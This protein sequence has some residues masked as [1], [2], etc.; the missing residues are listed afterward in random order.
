M[1]SLW[2]FYQRGFGLFPWPNAL[3]RI[4]KITELP[5]I[6]K[7][8]SQ[9]SDYQFWIAQSLQNDQ[10]ENLYISSNGKTRNINLDS[11]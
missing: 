6:S 4:S 7:S 2:I 8:E 1:G 3:P 10:L 5:K 11:S 9:K